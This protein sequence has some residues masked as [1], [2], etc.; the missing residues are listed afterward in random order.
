VLS[1]PQYG[2]MQGAFSDRTV[3]GSGSGGTDICS[4]CAPLHLSRVSLHDIGT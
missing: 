2:W 4:A 1:A 3:I